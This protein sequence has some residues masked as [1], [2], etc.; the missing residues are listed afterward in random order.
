MALH[1]IIFGS[2]GSGKGTQANELAKKYALEHVSTGA[3]F[4]SEMAK[5][6]D[7]GKQLAELLNAGNLVPDEITNKIAKNKLTELEGFDKGYV[8]DGFPRTIGQAESIEATRIDH[9]FFLDISDEVAVERL[10][11]RYKEAPEH[12]RRADDE[13]EESIKRRL[14]LYHKQTKPL[15]DYY[16]EKGLLRMIDGE[17]TIPEV[18]ES[19]IDV[20]ENSDD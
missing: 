10:R 17:Q 14:E 12:E 7:L 2:Q 20:I 5:D 3:I 9:V 8:L 15:I 4:R 6:T 11:L 19:L 13:N 18:T 16:T 1:L